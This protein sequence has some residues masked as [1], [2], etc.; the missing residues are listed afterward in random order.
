MGTKGVGMKGGGG[1]KDHG[2]GSGVKVLGAEAKETEQHPS[3]VRV[4]RVGR[5]GDV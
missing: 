2:G 4:G 5:D 1:E 3:R